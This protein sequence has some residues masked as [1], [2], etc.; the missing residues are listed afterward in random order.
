MTTPLNPDE[1]L[2]AARNCVRQRDYAQAIELF[3]QVLAQQPNHVAAHEGLATA[4]FLSDD[5]DLAIEHFKK[6]T[7]FDPRRSEALV[8]LGAVYNRKED[9]QSA[10][11]CLRKA[12]AKD[13]KSATAYYNLGLAHRGLGQS[14]MAV[15]AY[16][17]AIRLCPEMAEAYQNLANV[18]TDMGNST[19]AILH[20]ERALALRPDFERAQRGLQRA[21]AAK[22]EADRSVSP[23]GRLVDP[24]GQ[25]RGPLARTPVRELNDQQRFDDRTTVH[26]LIKEAEQS[27]SA[28]VHQVRSELEAQLLTFTRAFAQ[29]KDARGFWDEYRTLKQAIDNFHQM[30]DLHRHRMD[31]LQAHE[32]A[33]G[34]EETPA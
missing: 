20:Y 17:E 15:S 8:N 27:A 32:R 16:K 7:M 22:L 21:R 23:F 3:Q 13:R 12:L 5:Y 26:R 14:S 24:V 18:Y 28:L 33:M 10:V 30:Y 25:S 6:V 19:Q 9:Y 4:A 34:G 1:V 31:A 11:A 2:Q 29:S